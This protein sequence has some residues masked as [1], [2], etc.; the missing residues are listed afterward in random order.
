MDPTEPKEQQRLVRRLGFTRK[1]ISSLLLLLC[2]GLVEYRLVLVSL[3]AVCCTAIGW[4]AGSAYFKARLA[5]HFE[6]H[7][8]LEELYGDKH[9]RNDKYPD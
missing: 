9:P 2:I 4:F 1:E 5:T 7:M 3:S 6:R 8:L